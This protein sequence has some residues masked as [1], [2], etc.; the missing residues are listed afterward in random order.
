MEGLSHKGVTQFEE[1][2]AVLKAFHDDKNENTASIAVMRLPRITLCP[3]DKNRIK[4]DGGSSFCEASLKM[5][6]TKEVVDFLFWM[7]EKRENLQVFVRSSPSG[8]GKT[9]STYFAG[10]CVVWGGLY[11]G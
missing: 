11:C 2:L 1:V 5:L 10:M 4:Y 9:F 6:V 8:I 7:N 3:V